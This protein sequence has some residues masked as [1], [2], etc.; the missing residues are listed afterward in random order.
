[1]HTLGTVLL[2]FSILFVP[3]LW[4]IAAASGYFGL[5]IL[6]DNIFWCAL[7]ASTFLGGVIFL[8]V[9]DILVRLDKLVELK[10]NEL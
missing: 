2:V 8:A 10:Q 9:A 4:L 6:A 1:M 5:A 7:G 3:F